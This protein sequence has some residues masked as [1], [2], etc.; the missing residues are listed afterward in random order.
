VSPAIAISQM[1]L[2]LAEQ[3]S[4]NLNAP[5]FNY[6]MYLD[7]NIC[8]S[9]H[10]NWICAILNCSWAPYGGSTIVMATF[11]LT[12]HV[13][14]IKKLMSLALEELLWVLLVNK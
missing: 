8:F 3:L 2:E 10:M 14:F 11:I 9:P 6:Y 4:K 5:S 13:I 7:L 12:N 1:S